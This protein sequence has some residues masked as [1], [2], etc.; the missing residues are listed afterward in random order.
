MSALSAEFA[1][2]EPEHAPEWW[3]GLRRQRR[4]WGEAAGESGV[5]REMSADGGEA[6]GVARGGRARRLRA[7]DGV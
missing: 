5:G 7:C 3:N 1:A 2:G 6:A 4:G